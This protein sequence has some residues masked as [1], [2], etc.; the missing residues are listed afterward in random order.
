MQAPTAGSVILAGVLLKVG[1]YGFARFNLAMLPAATAMLMPW[2]LWISA[3]GIVYGALVALGQSDIKRLI[4]YSSV[5]H[6]G[7]CMLG[8]FAL[9]PPGP[10]GRRAANGQSRAIDR[11]AVCRGGDDLR[12]FSH[13]ANRRLWRPG[14][15]AARLEL[16]YP[17]AALS[18]IGLPGLNGFVGEFLILL[19]MF[20]RGFGG[21]EVA[22]A[23]WLQFRIIALLSTSGVVLGAWYMLWMYQRVFFG[24]CPNF[25]AHQREAVVGENGTVPLATKVRTA[26]EICRFVKLPAS[27]RFWC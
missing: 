18:S 8:L 24:D 6:L 3:A 11:R 19:G 23:H 27:R 26:C 13:A 21:H 7:F 9:N 22:S 12:A 15:A 2:L 10:P 17:R 25:R 1:T 5:S 16:L 14:S 20:Q 4:A